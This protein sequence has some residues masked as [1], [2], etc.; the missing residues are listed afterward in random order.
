MFKKILVGVDGSRY[1]SQAVEVAIDLAR[2]HQA[3]VI[4]VHA[5]RDLSLPKEILQM[6]QA[7]EVTQSRLEILQDSAE[8]ILDNA[9][10]KFKEAGL[11]G[12]QREVIFGDPAVQIARYAEEQGADLIVVGYRGLATEG[13]LLGGV[14]RKLLHV[15]GV[16]CLVVR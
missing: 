9:A 5:I 11:T 8:I 15:A 10:E 1:A 4:L 2:C 13:N 16:S 3:S 12:I 7:G 14:A 6:I